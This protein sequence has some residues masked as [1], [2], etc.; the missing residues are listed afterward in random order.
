MTDEEFV[1]RSSI[2]AISII[3]KM[4]DEDDFGKCFLFISKIYNKHYAPFAKPEHKKEKKK[5]KS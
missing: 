3:L 2:D 5:W 4:F 1:R